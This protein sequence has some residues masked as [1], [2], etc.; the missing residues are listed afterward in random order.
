MDGTMLRAILLATSLVV[1]SAAPAYACTCVITAPFGAAKIQRPWTDRPAIFTALVLEVDSP[2]DTTLKQSVRLLTEKSW[3]GAMPDIVTLAVSINSPCA[4]YRPGQRYLV[5]AD[6]APADRARLVTAACDDAFS[7]AGPAAANM[8]A[9]LGE[10]NWTAPPTGSRALDSLVFP[11]G[12]SLSR[13]RQQGRVVFHIP[14]HGVRRFEIGDQDVSP[15]PTGGPI[16][17]LRP[18]LYAFRI[19][20]TDGRQYHS[21]ISIRCEYQVEDFGCAVY[22]S[23]FPPP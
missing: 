4:S 7:F 13:I 20:W 10:P 8:R 9:E 21:Y 1:V 5:L 15:D 11:L 16:F 23:F 17:H 6:T 2:T 18:G 3:R 14:S 19:T 12:T 22:R